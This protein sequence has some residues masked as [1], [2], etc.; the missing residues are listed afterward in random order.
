MAKFIPIVSSAMVAVKYEREQAR[1]TVQFGEDVFYEYDSVPGDVVLD[2]L[3]ADS[4]GSAFA[5][6]VK[7]PGFAFRKLPANRPRA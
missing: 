5:A 2:F 3:F 7:K 6:L 1:L 4:I